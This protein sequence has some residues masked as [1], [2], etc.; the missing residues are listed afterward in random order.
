MGRKLYATSAIFRSGFDEASDA[1]A[2]QSQ[3]INLKSEI[4]SQTKSPDCTVS[5][6]FLF[7]LQHGLAKLL[8]HISGSHCVIAA[9]IGHSTGELAAAECAGM[10]SLDEAAWLVATRS[11]LLSEANGQGGM[12]ALATDEEHA[13]KYLSSAAEDAAIAAL[14]SS[15]ST[16]ISGSNEAIRQITTQAE[17]DGIKCTH[18]S[19]PIPYPFSVCLFR[20]TRL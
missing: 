4:Q 17:R 18:L 2:R 20:E 16:V 8:S 10:L 3:G 5:H 1:I 13:Q 11:R 15:V 9:V 12:L 7:A 19:V 14:N 6:P